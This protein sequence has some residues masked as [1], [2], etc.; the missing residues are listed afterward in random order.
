MDPNKVL[1]DAREA[2]ARIDELDRRCEEGEEEYDYFGQYQARAE[3]ATAAFRALDDWIT[4]GGF[5]PDKW[6][7]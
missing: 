5:L 6:R 7:H 2:M 3:V 4:K 1:E